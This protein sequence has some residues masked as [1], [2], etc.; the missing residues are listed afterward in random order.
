MVNRSNSA[1]DNRSNSADDKV[2]LLPDG[3]QATQKWW[4]KPK[5]LC[6]LLF[7]IGNIS[8]EL[9]FIWTKGYRDYTQQRVDIFFPPNHAYL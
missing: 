8:N 5:Y 3:P 4:K 2:Y 1:D 7:V 6:P 9:Q